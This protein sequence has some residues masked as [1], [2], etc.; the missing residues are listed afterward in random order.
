LAPEVRLDVGGGRPRLAAVGDVDGNGHVDL[1][2]SVREGA[3]TIAVIL[4]ESA[5]V[6]APAVPYG[7][8]MTTFV[9]EMTDL[10]GDDDPDVVVS[11]GVGVTV[12]RN[13]GDG[14]FLPGVFHLVFDAPIVYTADLAVADVNGDFHPDIIAVNDCPLGCDTSVAVLVNAGDGTFLAPVPLDLG[15]GH[16]GAV[17]A[18]HLNDDAHVDLAVVDCNFPGSDLVIA[19]NDGTGAFGVATRSATGR[20]CHGGSV[21]TPEGFALFDVDRDGD[22]DAVLTSRLDNEVRVLTNRGD[23]TFEDAGAFGVGERPIAAATGDLDGVG[24]DDVVTADMAIGGTPTVSVLINET[25]AGDP[26]PADIDGTGAVDVGDLLALL[27]EWGPCAGCPEDLD[28][29]GA[30]DAA[31]LV[32]LLADWGPCA[33]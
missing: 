17:R 7:K 33:S 2:A 9:L 15:V 20:N 28:E 4:A 5:G 18:A 25:P 3:G 24:G 14:T 11:L 19:L 21:T 16:V 27:A 6:F 23:L 26:C 30:V 13:A 32:R 1:V 22:A 10:D 29:S 31:D 8:S 12:F